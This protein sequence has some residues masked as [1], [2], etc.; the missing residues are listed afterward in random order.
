[1]Q[2][3]ALATLTL[4]T[5]CSTSEP[6][7]GH[8]LDID[9]ELIGDRKE[10]STVCMPYPG[11]PLSGNDLLVLINKEPG[12]QLLQSWAPTDLV[13]IPG[14]RMMPGR[15]GELRLGAYLAFEDMVE[16]ARAEDDLDLVVRS[17]YRSF[18]TQCWTFDF[19]VQQHGL[20]HAKR[21][22]AEPGRSQHQLGTTVDITSADLGY[23]LTQ[24]MGDS[25]EG[26]WLAANA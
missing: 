10:D 18:V 3:R 17:A 15:K 23:A 1:M 9:P 16:A 4:L 20:A 6:Q 21:F 7:V 5:A 14:S 26:Q 19:K 11:G 25:A 24:S 8:D 13:A 22:S 12:Q 2:R